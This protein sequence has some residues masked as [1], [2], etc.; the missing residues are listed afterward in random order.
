MSQWV[1]VTGSFYIYSWDHGIGRKLQGF[2]RDNFHRIP[3]GSEGALDWG[4]MQSNTHTTGWDEE[5]EVFG[6]GQIH[7]FGSLRDMTVKEFEEGLIDFM[8]ILKRAYPIRAAQVIV[9]GFTSGRKIYWIR[10]DYR[11][12]TIRIVDLSDQ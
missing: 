6:R 4:V 9:D 3:E 5:G 12:D 7:I 1:Q 8:Q 11:D 10:D 2:M